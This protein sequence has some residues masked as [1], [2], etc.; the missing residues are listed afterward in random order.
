MA[1][2]QLKGRHDSRKASKEYIAILKEASVEDRESQVS[3]FLE[4]SLENGKFVT[5]SQVQKLFYSLSVDLPPMFTPIGDL[6]SY[7]RLMGGKE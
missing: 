3:L 2:E 6:E 1:W 7:G 4:R 5:A